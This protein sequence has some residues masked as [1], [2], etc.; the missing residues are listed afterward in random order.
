MSTGIK[1]V[2]IQDAV[3]EAEFGDEVV[4]RGRKKTLT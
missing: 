4:V 2:R 3:D 1:Y